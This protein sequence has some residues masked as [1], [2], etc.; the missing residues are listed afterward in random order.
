MTISYTKLK[1]GEWGIRSD[2]V[3]KEGQAV[4][5]TI[6]TG[7]KA[8]QVKTETVKKIVWTNAKVWLAAIEPKK[9][10]GSARRGKG[11][12]E[13]EECGDRVTPGSQCWETG[14]TH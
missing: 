11:P 9:D 2:S 5:V 7:A 4:S 8:G 1:S 14:M 10:A 13:C 12:Y 6:K 3:V